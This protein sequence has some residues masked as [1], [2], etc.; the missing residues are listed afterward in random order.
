MKKVYD[1]KLTEI[2]LDPAHKTE[3]TRENKGHFEEL[4]TRLPVTI[5]SGLCGWCLGP[6]FPYGR[7]LVIH[8]DL[9]FWMFLGGR[10]ASKKMGDSP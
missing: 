6:F 7:V 5:A 1:A 8:T 3:L 9:R 10:K 2:T 4:M